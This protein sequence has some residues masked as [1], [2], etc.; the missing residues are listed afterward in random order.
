MAENLN[1]KIIQWAKN[2]GLDKSDPHIQ[3]TKVMEELGELNAAMNKEKRD[4]LIDSFGD[5][6]VALIILAS[7]LGV[8]YEQSLESA[9][10]VISNRTGKTINGVFV[11]SEDM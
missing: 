5:V 10:Q 6:Q 4:E 3:S 2:R 8:D 7:Q 1:K 11:K 9:Y